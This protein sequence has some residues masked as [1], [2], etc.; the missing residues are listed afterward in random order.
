MLV[1]LVSI[2]IFIFNIFSRKLIWGLWC[3]KPLSTFSYI[4]AVSLI[5]GEKGRKLPPYRK[6]LTNCITQCCIEYTSPWQTLSHNV[7]SSTPRHDKLYHTM[8]YRVHLAMSGWICKEAT[9]K[10]KRDLLMYILPW[11]RINAQNQTLLVGTI[12]WAIRMSKV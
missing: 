10:F 2:F 4:V 3:L 8:L 1:L 5:G 6:S 12:Y 11:S 7:V 9:N